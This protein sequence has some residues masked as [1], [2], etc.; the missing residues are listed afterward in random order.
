M[1]HQTGIE[2][3]PPPP[4]VPPRDPLALYDEAC[5]AYEDDAAS[6][7]HGKGKVTEEDEDYMEEDVD[8][9]NNGGDD[10]DQD[11]DDDYEDE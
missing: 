1:E 9:D 7:P 4:F 11:D 6:H 8:E 2:S 5:A 3:S 10:G